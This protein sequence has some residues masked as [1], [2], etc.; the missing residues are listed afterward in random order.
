MKR[1]G[2]VFLVIAFAIALMAA[3]AS[4][5]IFNRSFAVGIN[6][7]QGGATTNQFAGQL[8]LAPGFKLNGNAGLTGAG[9]FGSAGANSAA[10]G[11]LFSNT[12]GAFALGNATAIGTT[13]Q[14]AGQLNLAP[15]AAINANLGATIAVSGSQTQANSFAGF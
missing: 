7:A 1:F 12:S 15:G 9:A 3:P 2:I 14:F 13:N 10:V 8:N 6:N 11:G 5:G 4:A